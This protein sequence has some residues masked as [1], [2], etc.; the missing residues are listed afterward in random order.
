[1]SAT[2]MKKAAKQF[3]DAVHQLL[4]VVDSSP[5]T[6]NCDAAVEKY[7][8]TNA[9]ELAQ[10]AHDLGLRLSDAKTYSHSMAVGVLKSNTSEAKYLR[11]LKNNNQLTSEY[12]QK[13]YNVF[14]GN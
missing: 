7:I 12:H 13:R 1:M 2:I 14:F 10:T 11:Y 8:H 5:E 3:I 6:L 9:A 4:T